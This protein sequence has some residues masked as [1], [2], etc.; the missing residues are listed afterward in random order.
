LKEAFLLPHHD[1]VAW[2]HPHY[3]KIEDEIRGMVPRFK[4]D[5]N[6]TLGKWKEY[7]A[8]GFNPEVNFLSGFLIRRNNKKVNSFNEAWYK[9][10]LETI[11]FFGQDETPFNYML[12]K[13][14]MVY[15]EIPGSPFRS[16]V[17]R[18]HQHN[19]EKVSGS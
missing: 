7:K 15:G 8:A 5:L 12:W 17:A 6:K 2:R 11:S 9:N 13:R 1:L 10:Y 16:G 14:K 3:K 18:L 19:K 4:L